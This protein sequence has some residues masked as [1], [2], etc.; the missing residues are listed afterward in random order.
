[1]ALLAAALPQQAKAEEGPQTLNVAQWEDPVTLEN[2]SGRETVLFDGTNY[3]IWYSSSDETTLYH[4]SSTK[5]GLSWGH[6][7]P[8]PHVGLSPKINPSTPTD[9]TLKY[10]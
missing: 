4:T 7:Q 9:R 6:S 1:V 2:V 10:L 3:H 8:P 5:G